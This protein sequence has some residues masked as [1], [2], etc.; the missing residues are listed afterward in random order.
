MG[1]FDTE[2]V[3]CAIGEHGHCPRRG[4]RTGD[5][6]QCSCSCHSHDPESVVPAHVTRQALRTQGIQPG[7][8]AEL[9]RLQEV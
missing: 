6:W 5:F 7:T 9:A 4:E 3:Q 2:T 1:A 8:R